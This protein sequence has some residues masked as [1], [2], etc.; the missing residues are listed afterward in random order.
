MTNTVAGR[1]PEL[2]KQWHPILNGALQAHRVHSGQSTQR[3]FWKCP[4]GP[5]HV[6]LAVV[7]R[8][9][10][11]HTGCPACASASSLVSVTNS[12][13]IQRPLI[14]VMF[15]AVKNYPLLAKDITVGA[16]VR[17]HWVCDRN[18][19]HKWPAPVARLTKP[20]AS[21]CP[22]CR[23]I[24][25]SRKSVL[26]A[27]EI[28]FHVP[29]EMEKKVPQLN[30]K[31]LW[32]F[33]FFVEVWN[34]LVDFDGAFWHSR[35]PAKQRERDIRKANDAKAQGYNVIRIRESELKK[36]CMDWDVEVPWNCAPHRVARVVLLKVQEK[37]GVNIPKMSLRMDQECSLNAESAQL[38]MKENWAK[39]DVECVTE[40]VQL[41][42]FCQNSTE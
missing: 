28:G 19:S 25:E 27:H 22:H 4:N 35:R 17:Y 33:D 21:G 8:R 2:S 42:L 1:Y 14:A 30:S 6:W 24:R 11:K 29:V 40:A 16:S 36:L 32:S 39:E 34:L 31:R 26:I 3:V 37:L 7:D 41:D 10:K 5:D 18:D 12:L 23:Q 9:T 38:W 13:L 20:T 15:D